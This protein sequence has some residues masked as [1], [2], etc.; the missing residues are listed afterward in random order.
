MKREVQ[1][2]A[3]Q[4]GNKGTTSNGADPGIRERVVADAEKWVH[5]A[6]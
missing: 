2:T 3:G 1:S 4:P 6:A 5:F